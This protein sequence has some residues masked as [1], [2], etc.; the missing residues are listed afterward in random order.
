[1]QKKK[2]NVKKSHIATIIITIIGL[3]I[4]ALVLNWLNSSNE[5][6]QDVTKITSPAEKGQ[7]QTDCLQR[8]Y[9]TPDYPFETF[10][11]V[12]RSISTVSSTFGVKNNET[13]NFEICIKNNA[14][15]ESTYH[16]T[17]NFV[18]LDHPKEVQY[19]K[20][21]ERFVWD[22]TPIEIASGKYYNGV[23]SF[24]ARG[25]PVGIY[26]F[27]ANLTCENDCILSD[28]RHQFLISVS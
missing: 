18:A 22:K 1:M 25:L 2:G 27:E 24:N 6:I 7:Y 3:T 15:P 16:F 12:E 28:S 8:T 11:Y 21:L 9:G 17:Y 26:K 19:S 20:V 10:A 5:N 4:L 23:V 13:I 14:E